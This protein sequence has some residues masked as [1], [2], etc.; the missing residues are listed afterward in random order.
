MCS[1]ERKPT[2]L[3]SWRKL[4]ASWVK[5]NVDGSC[6]RNLGPCGGK[7]VIQDHYGNLVA[8]FFVT[9]GY[10]KNSEAELRAVMTGIGEKSEKLKALEVEVIECSKYLPNNDANLKR[11]RE[12]TQ[13]EVQADISFSQHRLL[14]KTIYIVEIIENLKSLTVENA[15]L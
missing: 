1:K 7:G 12:E 14:W 9:Y 6:F 3:V 10:G 11:R 8:G 2:L 5:L 13:M 4:A 15:S